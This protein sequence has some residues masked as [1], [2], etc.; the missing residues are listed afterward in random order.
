MIFLLQTRAVSKV[1]VFSRFILWLLFFYV[2]LAVRQEF[3]KWTNEVFPIRKDQ[4]KRSR[5]APT[6]L[7]D[8][9][10]ARMNYRKAY[11]RYLT[12]VK[13]SVRLRCKL[14]ARSMFFLLGVKG[15]FLFLITKKEKSP[16]K[17]RCS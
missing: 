14:T 1:G 15:G 11:A 6:V 10:K 8:I 17:P 13:Y 16:L 7:W 5:N 4:A 12:N 2:L 3:T 9:S